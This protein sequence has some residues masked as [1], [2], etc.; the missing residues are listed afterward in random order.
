MKISIVTLSFNQREYLR[1]AM[2]SILSQRYPELEYIIV[3]PGSQ[4]GSRELIVGYGG[5]IT[6]AIF[7]PDRGAADGLN[8][9][10]GR[11]TGEICGFLNADDILF[12][13]SLNRVANFFRAHPEC[14]MMMGNGYVIDEGGR[15]LRRIVARDFSVRRYL[16]G[17]TSWMQQSTFFRRELF[18]RSSRFNLSNRSCWDGEL[19]L[20]MADQ[21]A[22]I[23]YI[24]ADLSGFRIHSKSIT[25][26]GTNLD[27]YTRD[28][29]RIFQQ[30]TGRRWNTTDELLR[31]LYRTE[32]FLIRIRSSI[33]AIATRVFQ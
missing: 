28:C 13:G 16:Y 9:G 19:F 12:P 8:K 6:A 31:F 33:H 18:L 20:A 26:S 23:G 3:D 29:R 4:D 17:G 22:K 24:D 25:G 1:E 21:G 32:G 14:D 11:A 2:D 7:E 15:K 30:I 5:R 10:F 27:V